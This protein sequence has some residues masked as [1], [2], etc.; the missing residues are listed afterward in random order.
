MIR[1]ALYVGDS[2][3]LKI[4]K[5][6]INKKFIITYVVSTDKKYEMVIKKICNQNMIKFF[7][8]DE[9][10]NQLSSRYNKKTDAI[11]SI[12]SRYIFPK[13][14]I[15]SYKGYIFNMHPGLLPF[16]PGTNSI[17][18]TLYNHEKYTGST[19]HLVTNKI[20]GGDIVLSKKFKL[21][22]N[23]LA[24]TVW[25]KIQKISLLLA[26][27]FY[28]K[29]SDDK[30]IFKKNDT[31]KSKIFPKFIPNNGIIKPN[32]DDLSKVLTLYRASYFYPFKSPWG[33]LKILYKKKL[34]TINNIKKVN[35]EYYI[36]K[37]IKKINSKIYLVKLMANKIIQVKIN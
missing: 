10:K 12:F 37:D 32:L 30:L 18:G 6:Y 35:S 14:F 20:D 17:S 24:M 21:K 26:R 25:Q 13:K 31:N 29:V 9:I 7:F 23:D 36:C 33:N 5:D 3:G 11:I 2:T 34:L 15:K 22:K 8:I 28:K 1:I 16:Y 4:L 19:I 27:N